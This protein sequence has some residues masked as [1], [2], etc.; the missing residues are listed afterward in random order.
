M[1]ESKEN[2]KV[3]KKAVNLLRKIVNDAVN[4]ANAKFNTEHKYMLNWLSITFNEDKTLNVV[5]SVSY[6][7]KFTEVSQDVKEVLSLCFS[8]NDSSVDK[9]ELKE[10]FESL[11]DAYTKE[12]NRKYSIPLSLNMTLA[13]N[14]NYKGFGWI[15]VEVSPL[16]CEK[17]RCEAGLEIIIKVEYMDPQ[18]AISYA[19]FIKN[20]LIEFLV[21]IVEIALT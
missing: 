4:K 6:S 8:G 1:Q 5:F 19:G 9:E 16:Y 15:T 18:Y 11:Y 17:D 12:I 14:K 13:L 10:A 2:E 20:K 7:V 3:R 21:R